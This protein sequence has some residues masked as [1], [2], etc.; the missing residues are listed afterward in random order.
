MAQVSGTTDTY[1]LIGI[2]EDVEDAIFNISPT[3]TPFLTMAKRK[4]VSNTY[5]QWQ[6]DSLAAAAAN[7]QVEGDDASFTTATPTTMLGNYTQISRK[8]V[9]VSRTADTVR[10]YGR[11]KE[12][13]RLVTKYGKELKRDIE[14]ALVRNQASSAGGTATAR[15]SA[16][17]ES[18]I[19]GNRILV[20]STNTTGTTPGFSG[21]VWS[22]PTDGTATVT[23][24]EA[25]LVNGIQAAW[26]DGGDPSTLMMNFAQKKQLASFG[27][28]Q[29]F[30]GT[31]VPNQGRSVQ[32]MV[33]G[34]VDFYV[35][36]VGEHRV[37]LN[38]YMRDSVI[39]GLDAEYISVGFLD[40]IKMIDLAK[41]GD[42]EKK[43]LITEFTLINDNP[44]AHF[45]IQDCA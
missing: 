17:L 45:K 1:D 32:S 8:T 5:H 39:F 29:K 40:G 35:S 44:D 9:V 16:G 14:F 26:T 27:G 6:T 24:S 20:T 28:A 31:Y 21:G 43:M 11:A 33:I 25:V 34:G 13:A 19:A 7:R 36:D 30:A 10:K 22:A 18:M 12:L 4:S 37:R 42:A 3:E 41:T 38:R 2:A 23:V 15:S